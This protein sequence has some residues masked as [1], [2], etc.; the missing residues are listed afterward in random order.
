MYFL[1]KNDVCME[2]E[3]LVFDFVMWYE[4]IRGICCE[5]NWNFLCYVWVGDDSKLLDMFVSECVEM[6][7]CIC[8]YCIKVGIKGRY[9]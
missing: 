3:L 4:E 5:I 8:L 1:L 6:V 7:F 9:L 2:V